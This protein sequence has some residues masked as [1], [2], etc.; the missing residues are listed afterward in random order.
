[1]VAASVMGFEPDE[2]PT[3]VCAN[4]VGL[5]PQSLDEIEVRGK[6]VQDVRRNFK[7][8]EMNPWTIPSSEYRECAS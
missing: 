3:F 2:V 7:K 5:Q 6:S 8:P 4:S 1:M